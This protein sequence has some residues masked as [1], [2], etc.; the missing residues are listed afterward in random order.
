MSDSRAKPPLWL[1]VYSA[2][3]AIWLAGLY[4][5]LFFAGFPQLIDSLDFSYYYAGAQIGLQHGWSHIYDL[6][7]QRQI[8]YQLHPA[9]DTFDWRRY[10]VSPPPVAWLV[11]PFSLFPLVPAFWTFT[12]LS[13]LALV[14][15][16]WLAVPGRSL[17]R[18]ALFISAAC[19]YPVLIAIQTGQVTPLIAAATLMAWWLARRGM[20][21][22]A[23]L[24]LVLVVLKPQAAILVAPALLIAGQRRL[25]VTWVLGAAVVTAVSVAMLGEHGLNALRGA[26]ALEQGRTANLV[27]TLAGLVGDG[28]LASALEIGCAA[29]A[30]AAAWRNRRSLELATVAGVVG[31]LLAFPYRNP[32]D[33]A[34]IAPAAW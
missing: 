4:L 3:L 15:C 5:P 18:V 23:G 10:F 6:D 2:V 21:V 34:L 19:T 30:L 9:G 7:L 16:G 12:S 26:L 27:W 32:S 31:S 8:F 11:A 17:A 29:V 13:A 33:Y 14:A 24:V 20:Q 25:F 22:G 1:A 28:P